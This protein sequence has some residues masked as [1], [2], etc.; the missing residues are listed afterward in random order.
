MLNGKGDKSQIVKLKPHHTKRAEIQRLKLP[1][2]I[3]RRFVRVLLNTGEY[4]VLVTHLLDET[5][6]PTEDFK[7]IYHLRWGVETFYGIL[8]TRL[9]LEN[10]TGKTAE[11]VYQDFYSSVDLTGLE[12]IL[13]ADTH[14]TLSEKPTV[15]R[16][17]VNRAVSFN[18][19]KNHAIEILL[20]KDDNNL[21]LKKLESL[22]LTNPTS[23]RENRKVT[24]KKRSAR[25]LLNYAKRRRKITY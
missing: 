16:Q 15:H 9:D 21:V 22:F 12:S 4:E 6:Y 8:K 14:S 24:R 23:Q 10:F 20:S 1:K 5:E 17:Q 13:T 18:A 19:I 11:S 3:T 7:S 2:E 25:H